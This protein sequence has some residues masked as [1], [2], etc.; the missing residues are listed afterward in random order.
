MAPV[1]TISATSGKNAAGIYA[2]A[3]KLE[4]EGAFGGKIELSDEEK[5]E[6]SFG[7]ALDENNE[8]L[9][10]KMVEKDIIMTTK[11]VNSLIHNCTLHDRIVD[12]NAINFRGISSAVRA[13]V[14]LDEGSRKLVSKERQIAEAVLSI[15]F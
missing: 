10:V 4:E 7:T 9:I 3:C 5:L 11:V 6:N 14:V 2:I 13:G 15:P 8:A 1:N 12:L